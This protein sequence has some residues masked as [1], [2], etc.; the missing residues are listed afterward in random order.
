MLMAEIGAEF[1]V[2]SLQISNQ[3]KTFSLQ[4]LTESFS[5]NQITQ[6]EIALRVSEGN[7]KLC[8]L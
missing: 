8:F 1:Y 2:I 6:L 4:E 3:D 7:Q 5:I